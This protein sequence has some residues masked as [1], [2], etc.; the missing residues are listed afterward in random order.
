MHDKNKLTSLRQEV[1]AISIGC[2]GKWNIFY[3]FKVT[4]TAFKTKV[5]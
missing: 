5:I 2:S 1:V 3:K 4:L